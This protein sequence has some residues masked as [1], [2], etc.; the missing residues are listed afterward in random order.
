M[1]QSIKCSPYQALYGF[2]K[3]NIKIAYEQQAE[4]YNV[5]T[6]EMNFKI[7]QG[8]FRRNFLQSSF[9]KG[10]SAKLAPTFIKSRVTE[11]L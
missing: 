4:R 7:E 3:E 6:K 8:V 10:I 1:H 11:K 5:R 9:A 2:K